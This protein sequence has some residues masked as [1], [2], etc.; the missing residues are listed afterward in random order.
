MS[1]F[2][3]Q[4]GDR[5]QFLGWTLPRAARG[6]DM[7]VNLELARVIVQDAGLGLGGKATAVPGT[8]STVNHACYRTSLPCR[9]ETRHATRS[10]AVLEVCPEPPEE[11]HGHAENR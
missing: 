4:E 10:D 5:A 9:V 2:L 7:A 8:Q 6:F 1:R 3:D 11:K